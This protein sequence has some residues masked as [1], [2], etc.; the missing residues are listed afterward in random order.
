LND[1]IT[2]LLGV[3]VALTDLSNV[4]GAAR[5]AVNERHLNT[6]AKV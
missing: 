6:R 1:A 3:R 2:M 4:G 5:E